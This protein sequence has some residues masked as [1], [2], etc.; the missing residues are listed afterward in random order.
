MPAS[1]SPA[2]PL[3]RPDTVKVG[4]TPKRPRQQI[5]NDEDGAFVGRILR[6]YGRP[7]ALKAD[8]GG[9]H[10]DHPGCSRGC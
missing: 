10:P 8:P 2:T 6:A 1:P 9:R 3:P 5:E 4:L 7:G